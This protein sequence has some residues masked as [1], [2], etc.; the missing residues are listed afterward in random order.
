METLLIISLSFFMTANTLNFALTN[1][2]VVDRESAGVT[3]GLLVFGGSSAA[4]LAPILT[5][6]IIQVTN[7]YAMAFI[8]AGV[9]LILG[10]CISWFMIRKP[11]Q[12]I[13][14]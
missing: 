10:A 7:S 4:L 8:L 9:L 2:L 12:P 6:F 3:T 14:R 1:D 11:L 13:S 5:G